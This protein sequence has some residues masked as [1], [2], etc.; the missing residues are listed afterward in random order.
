MGGM[1]GWMG[2]VSIPARISLPSTLLFNP[3]GGLTIEIG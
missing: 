1:G 3:L 2:L